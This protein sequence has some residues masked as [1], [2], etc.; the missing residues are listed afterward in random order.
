MLGV[1]FDVLWKRE[2]RR[3]FS[4][5]AVAGALCLAIGA[6]AVTE[7]RR[8]S[9]ERSEALVVASTQAAAGHDYERALRYSVLSVRSGWL[10]RVSTA[11]EVQLARVA[12]LSSQQLRIDALSKPPTEQ[13]TYIESS[14]HAFSDDGRYIA[15]LDGKTVTLWDM[16][17]GIRLT[18]I[19]HPSPVAA[20]AFSPEGGRLFSASLVSADAPLVARIS[21]VATGRETSRLSEVP[22]QITRAVFSRSGRSVGVTGYS[23]AGGSF[24]AVFDV[25]SGKRMMHLPLEQPSISDLA[26]S[27]NEARLVVALGTE[28]LV[29]DARDSTHAARYVHPQ[30]VERV[31]ISA[32]GRRVAIASYQSVRVWNVETGVL[33]SENKDTYGAVA[34]IR[35]ANDPPRLLYTTSSAAFRADAD[36][37][38]NVSRFGFEDA[39]WVA[40]SPDGQFVAAF[41]GNS[42]V[43][44]IGRPDL[45]EAIRAYHEVPA[46]AA[47]FTPNNDRV[48]TV[49]SAGVIRIFGVS[50]PSERSM[51]FT[52]G[53]A[54]LRVDIA[55]GQERGVATLGERAAML[56]DMTAGRELSRLQHDDTVVSAI[57]DVKGR[58]ILTAS[59][60][61]SARL[62][63]GS[64]GQELRRLLHGGAVKSATFSSDGDRIV[65]AAADGTARTWDADSGRELS[66]LDH[67]SPV[68]SAE[69][70]ASGRRVVTTAA[71]RSVNVWDTAS[72]RQLSRAVLQSAGGL[73]RL[74]IPIPRQVLP[75]TFSPDGA[76]VLTAFENTARLIDALSGKERAFFTHDSGPSGERNTDQ[77]VL[78]RFN[79]DGSRLV[80]AS[81]DGSTRVWSPMSGAPVAVVAQNAFITD[82]LL[83]PDSRRLITGSLD[84]TVR[85][86][87]V[88]TGTE[89]TRLA[90]AN[91]LARPVS[92]LTLHDS[93][94][95]VVG[96]SENLWAQSKETRYSWLQVWN[97][98]WLMKQGPALVGALCDQKMRGAR[99]VRAEDIAGAP[100]LRRWKSQD[101]CR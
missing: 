58:R 35:F 69:F 53:D 81:S 88:D 8:R 44:Q 10:D 24:A 34:S 80:T 56:L 65:T 94:R 49:D 38:G 77:V 95:L 64:T 40:F 25:K 96:L 47:M 39:K 101:V 66:R 17:R 100:A 14:R 23:D 7:V 52:G 87:D 30:S 46:V 33:M 32:D 57:F 74:P 86:W 42:R 90:A 51:L 2:Q 22:G 12:H 71:D 82:A 75:A 36:T 41:L 9:L 48:L 13:L 27:A 92:F 97:V 11:A 63:D 45:E 55:A 70:D 4:R 31:A 59:S 21:D 91:A 60:D 43:V 76:T 85:V 61:G 50:L 5:I 15:I 67:P 26:L 73:Y 29:V 28:A 79:G 37:G 99:L 1:K 98:S 78:A 68:L 3:L 72:A 6:G 54:P 93:D 18:P 89:V 16:G 20:F 84:G 83:S 62:F 19:D